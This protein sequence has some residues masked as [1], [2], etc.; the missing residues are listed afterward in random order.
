VQKPTGLPSPISHGS[1]GLEHDTSMS[2]SGVP[3][4]VVDVPVLV[5]DVPM[6]VDDV[7]VLVDDV[8][9]LAGDVPMLVD[10]VPVLAVDVLVLGDSIDMHDGTGLGESERVHT[11]RNV[12]PSLFVPMHAWPC[13]PTLHC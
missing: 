8:P 13:S 6:L 3:V 1:P 12:E 10:D 7:P 5:V 4:L 2:V 11:P 9:V